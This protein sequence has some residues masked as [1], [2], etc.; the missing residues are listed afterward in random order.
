MKPFRFPLVLCALFVILPGFAFS[1][2]KDASAYIQDVEFAL[3]ELPKHCGHFF[4]LK[5]I[6]WNAVEKEFRKEAQSVKTDGEH[7]VLLAR[8]VARLKDGHAS[9][10]PKDK[11][12]KWP[13]EQP[14]PQSGPG[15]FWCRSGKKIL[16]KNSWSAAAD[17]GIRPGMEVIKVDDTPVSKWLDEKIAARRDMG[18]FSTDHQAFFAACHWGL[19]GDQGSTMNVELRTLKGHKKV[20]RIIRRRA[21]CIPV[22]PA[23]FPKDLQTIGRQHYGKLKS[24]FGYIHLRDIP[25][26]FLEQLDKMLAAIGK[27]P[28]LILDCR[29]NGGGGC[30][31]D[32][33]LGRFV[34]AGKTLKRREANPIP[35]AGPNPYGG[36]LVVIVDAGCR[37]AGETVSGMFKED[38]RGYMIGESPTAGMSSQKETIELPSGRFSLYVSVRSNKARFNN[39]RGLEGIG[40]IPHKV[41]EYDPRDLDEEEDTLI[42]EAENILR[43]F[44]QKEVPYRP[45]DY[46]WS[47]TQ[48]KRR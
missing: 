19:A 1:Q 40:V 21:S 27:V 2:S 14:D 18:G 16:V 48:R 13:G 10:H 4:N 42:K 34:P 5:G 30:D 7:W 45:Q 24:G 9:V 17:T 15:M 46:G 11:S 25:N 20:A 43:H 44:P 8:M 31:H 6:D 36:P 28:G 26:E 35:S 23:F 47:F 32:A 3:K 33:A 37:S 29:S 39:G 22:G 41:I 38:G 12:L